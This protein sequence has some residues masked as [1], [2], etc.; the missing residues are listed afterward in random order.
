MPGDVDFVTRRE[1]AL[2]N[3]AIEPF[4]G[5]HRYRGVVGSERPKRRESWG[6]AVAAITLGLLAILVAIAFWFGIRGLF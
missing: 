5:P 3:V 1:G 6:L 4:T 2:P